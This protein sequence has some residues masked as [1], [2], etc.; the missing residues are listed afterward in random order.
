[1]PDALNCLSHVTW[2]L[3]T[4]EKCFETSALQDL[5]RHPSLLLISACLVWLFC[6]V[7]WFYSIV[8]CLPLLLS[9]SVSTSACFYYSFMN[10]CLQHVNEQTLKEQKNNRNQCIQ[11]TTDK[12]QR[13]HRR[14]YTRQN[15]GGNT[16]VWSQTR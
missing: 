7:F 14:I 11:L 10:C 2:V 6:T 9:A 8:C 15:M 12:R 13:K 16:L 1:M 4:L 3:V 5:R